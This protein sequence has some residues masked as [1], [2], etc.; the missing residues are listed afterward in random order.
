MGKI[1]LQGVGTICPPGKYHSGKNSLDLCSA[2]GAM[3]SKGTLRDA[4]GTTR[5]AKGTLR[6]ANGTLRTLRKC[7]AKGT[8]SELKGNAK[9]MLLCMGSSSTPPWTWGGWGGWN[10]FVDM[11]HDGVAKIQT[12]ENMPTL[13]EPSLKAN[14]NTKS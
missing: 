6:N 2:A 11:D 14:T 12:P 3:P 7:H 10:E 8:L 5:V 4:K 13:A 1:L 9:G